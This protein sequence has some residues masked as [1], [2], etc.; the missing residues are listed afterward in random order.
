VRESHVWDDYR[1]EEYPDP[2]TY[3]FSQTYAV[4]GVDWSFAIEVS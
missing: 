2:G 3:R 4:D 1:T